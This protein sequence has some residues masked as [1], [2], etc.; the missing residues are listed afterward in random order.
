VLNQP[1]TRHLSYGI[2]P[3]AFRLPDEAHVGAVRLQV[4]DL[5][6]SIEY[7]GQVLGLRVYSSARDTATLSPHGFERATRS[8]YE[9]SERSTDL[10]LQTIAQRAP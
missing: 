1:D 3:P 10:T 7:Y 9:V 5:R 6:R 8:R 4:S 2:A